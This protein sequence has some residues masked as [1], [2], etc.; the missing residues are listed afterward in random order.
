MPEYLSRLFYLGGHYYGSQ[1]QPGF[2]TVQ[3]ELIGALTKWSGEQ[4]QSPPSR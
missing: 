1:Y 4:N 3:G 2:V